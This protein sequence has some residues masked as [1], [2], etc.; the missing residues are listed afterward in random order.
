MQ[1]H[2]NC[3]TLSYERVKQI[4]PA[5]NERA[6]TSEDFFLLG[7]TSEI[8]I[9]EI[10]LKKRGYHVWD[11]GDDYIFIKKTLRGLK[12]LETAFHELFHAV[13]Q[14]PLKGM[15]AKQQLVANAFALIAL[16]PLPMLEDYSFLEENPTAHAFWLYKERLRVKFLYGI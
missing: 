15:H 4:I 16:I 11:D 1:S 10:K 2:N 5:F 13:L 9:A 3:I 8:D 6:L 7:E 14:A 12:W